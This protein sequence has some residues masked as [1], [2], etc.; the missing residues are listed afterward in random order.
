MTHGPQ[1]MLNPNFLYAI[2]PANFEDATGTLGDPDG[3]TT[4]PA[5][6]D[7]RA[8]HRGSTVLTV[9]ATLATIALALNGASLLW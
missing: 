7:K 5:R 4:I 6:Q 3:R 9:L 8:V 1:S 2:P